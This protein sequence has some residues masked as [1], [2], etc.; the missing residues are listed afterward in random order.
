MKRVYLLG[1]ALCFMMLS[2]CIDEK[3]DLDNIDTTAEFKVNDLV[4]PLNLDEIKLESLID[5]DESGDIRV[6]GNEYVFVKEGEFSSAELSV[7]AIHVPAPVIG[8]SRV[9][10]NI[11]EGID[12]SADVLAGLNKTYSFAINPAKSSFS[13]E[14]SGVAEEIKGIDRV[15]FDFAITMSYRIDGFEGVLSRY[16]Y[17]NIKMQLPKG[18]KCEVEPG[19]YD[20]TTGIF[21]LAEYDVTGNDA[22]VVFR[23]KEM[24][25]SQANA[26][27]SADTRTFKFADELRILEGEVE[28]STND[29]V[30]GAVLP[31]S[32]T[33]VN[34]YDATDLDI[35][36]FTGKLAYKPKGLEPVSFGIG[37]MPDLLNQKG[38]DI[39][40][41][42]PQ[43]YLK[44]ANPMSDYSMSADV[45]LE[46]VTKHGDEQTGVYVPD[47]GVFSVGGS[48]AVSYYCLSPSEPS[49]MQE[50][51]EGA[52]HVAFTSLSD[53]LSGDG[54]PDEI[55]ICADKLEI[56]VQQ[57]NDLP[58]GKDL[59]KLEGNYK[60][61]IPLCLKEGSTIVYT[62]TETGWSDSDL[63]KLSIGK[64]GLSAN[65]TTDC[66]V[67]ITFVAYPI[68]VYGNVV[69]GISITSI[70]VPANAQSEPFELMITGDIRH[71]D[72][73]IFMATAKAE[74]EQALSP[75]M[76]IKLENVK[77]KVS[78]NYV[79]ELE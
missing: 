6:I 41:A 40:I 65:V 13:N 42:N 8:S 14:V 3:Y 5:L 18:V 49:A 22:S 28:V 9:S 51:Y 60:L 76:K 43:V 66:P 61:F 27:F 4:I 79:T 15:K 67:G 56:P 46:V 38:T 1:I 62:K 53:V 11:P 69:D 55:I 45:V 35:H 74:Q 54:L 20:E 21:T 57:V 52:Q 75:E 47:N 19:E 50:G 37:V 31:K 70:A 78:G 59:G 34:S 10:V 68:D 33:L 72:G 71:L 73:I 44:F 63:E 17:K 26:E 64:L 39:R 32:A 29:I 16:K 2:S 25:M 7:P 24:D 48:S 36:E 77:V 23:F 12:I 58:L 30:P